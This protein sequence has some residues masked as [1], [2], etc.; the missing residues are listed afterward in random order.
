MRVEICDAV[1]ASG[2]Y[3]SGCFNRN[4]LVPGARLEFPGKLR[5]S[6][7]TYLVPGG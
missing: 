1:D 2:A 6:R 4:G 5:L 3:D 7:E